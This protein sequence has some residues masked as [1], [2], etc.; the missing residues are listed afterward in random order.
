ML[1]V[2]TSLQSRLQLPTMR[3]LPILLLVLATAA[4]TEA[5]RERRKAKKLSSLYQASYEGP[6]PPVYHT[7]PSP[8]S[9]STSTT[10][11][12]PLDLHSKEFC[13]DVSAYQPV[14]WEERE[15]EECSTV[16]VRQCQERRQN[17]CSTVT[18][19]RCEVQPYTECSL[20]QE[21]QQFNKTVLTAKKFVEKKCSRTT[22][23][24]PHTKYVPECHNVTKQSKLLSGCKSGENLIGSEQIV[25]S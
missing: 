8:P 9:T 20:G 23:T 19:T 25:W 3:F 4:T 14:V 18:E 5:S 17:V 10:A 15:A 1:P 16:F 21:P 24:V 22:D 13:V 6:P 11:A 12:P 2:I 7:T